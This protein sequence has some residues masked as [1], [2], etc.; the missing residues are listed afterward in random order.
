MNIVSLKNLEISNASKEETIDKN[1][2][3]N[4]F[5]EKQNFCNILESKEYFISN[6]RIYLWM[7]EFLLACLLF[8]LQVSQIGHLGTGSIW[9]MIFCE[10]S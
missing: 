3:L 2:K 10:W 1:I 4:I 6:S 9:K 7:G 8:L 5:S